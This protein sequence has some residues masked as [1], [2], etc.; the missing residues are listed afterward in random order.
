MLPFMDIELPR[1]NAVPLSFRG[2]LVHEAPG[3]V[4]DKFQR[5]YDMTLYTIEGG[6]L[7]VAIRY[8]TIHRI[9]AVT[10]WALRGTSPNAMRRELMTWVRAH[11]P[12]PLLVGFPA[13]EQFEKKLTRTADRLRVQVSALAQQILEHV[14]DG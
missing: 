2:A 4:I 12:T 1:F 13:G 6:G 5:A 8:N 11:D 3:P 10:A 7:A 9:E 14:T